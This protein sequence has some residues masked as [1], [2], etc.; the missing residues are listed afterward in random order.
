[1]EW[2]PTQFFRESDDPVAPFALLVLNQPINERAFTV[3]N[4]HGKSLSLSNH[5]LFTVYL[6]RISN[7]ALA[8]SILHY[9]RRRRR[10]PLLRH[11]A[12]SQPGINRHSIRP[13]VRAHYERLGVRILKDADQY[14]TDF[15]KCLKYL[16]AHAAEIIAGRRATLP[17][18]PPRRD[19]RL[20]ILVMGGLGGRVDQALSQIHHLYVMTREVAE[21]AAAAAAAAVEEEATVG[22]LYLISE[23]SIT[24][25]L[26]SGKHTIRTPRTNRPGI[27]GRG[28]SREEEGFYLL[29]ENV[30]IIPLSGPAR[31]TTH[32]FEWDVA[33]WLTEIGGRV[34]TSNHI[35]ADVVS[36]ETRVPVLF[37]LELAER[38]K[39]VR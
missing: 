4:D 1:M 22:N 3:L 38:F 29:E 18:P 10:K 35:R 5:D 12:N 13:S 32:G 9:L 36:V 7:A 26:Q 37:T 33:D 28:G 21:S 2:D 20:E 27:S 8:S 19:T 16:S 34:S 24:F 14:S 11:D 15:T 31:I 23:E 30:G 25:V 39:R 6:V 17:P